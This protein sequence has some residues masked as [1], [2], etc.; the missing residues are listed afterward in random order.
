MS[1][2]A[3]KP[4]VLDGFTRHPGHQAFNGFVAVFAKGRVSP[5][6]DAGGHDDFSLPESL[7]GVDRAVLDARR[8]LCKGAAGFG[9]PV[10][11]NSEPLQAF[12]RPMSRK[13]AHVAKKIDT[14]FELPLHLAAGP[15]LTGVSGRPQDNGKLQ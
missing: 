3:S 6:N 9:W 5:A 1:S 14:V 10:S 4:G 8:T 7:S 11:H 12:L 13:G 15:C 2:Q